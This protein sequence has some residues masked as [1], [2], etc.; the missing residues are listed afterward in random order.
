M[1]NLCLCNRKLNSKA[2]MSIRLPVIRGT[3]VIR[4][5]EKVSLRLRWP[6]G[7]VFLASEKSLRGGHTHRYVEREEERLVGKSGLGLHHL[8]QRLKRFA[9]IL[10]TGSG[11]SADRFC[12]VPENKDSE[13]FFVRLHDGIKVPSSAS[14]PR[15]ASPEL[16]QRALRLAL[17]LL[18]YVIQIWRVTDLPY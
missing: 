17:T 8:I 4:L 13:A 1:F 16:L 5:Q 6:L 18:F 12:T 2:T 11:A 15:E 14:P 3:A 9:A 7:L 10:V